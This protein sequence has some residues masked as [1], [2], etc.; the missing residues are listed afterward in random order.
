M[1]DISSEK[2][3]DDWILSGKNEIYSRLEKKYDSC[4]QN[5]VW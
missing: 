2:L 4:L 3:L 5:I 1:N